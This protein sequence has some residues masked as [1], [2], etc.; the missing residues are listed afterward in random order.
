MP[1]PSATRYRTT[2]WSDYNAALR[3]RGSLSVWFDPE[4][5][6]HAKK[7]GKRGRPETFS[8]AAIQTCLTL[9]VLFGLPLRQTVGQAESL[10][11]M[12]GLDW[13]V[14][15]HSTLCRR[16]ARIAVQVPYRASRQPLNLLV[17]NEASSAIGPR[18]MPNGIKF[19]GDGEWQARKHGPSR[20]RQW[21]KVHI[22][23]D[24]GTGDVRAVE[25]TSSR[26]GDSPL[27]PE[28]LGQIPPEE[29]IGMV[30]ADGAYDTRRCHGAIIDRGADA[31]IPIRRNGRAWKEDCPAAA[32]R[33]E[34]LRATRRLGRTLWKKW[35]G[36]HVRSRV[37]ARMN[38]L[39]L[40]GERIMSRDPDRQ[41]AEIQIRIAI[42]NRFSALGRAEI[43]AVR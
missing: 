25:F 34:I 17:D 43:E 22:A 5:V 30:T 27:L 6:W 31:V 18:T 36:Y 41:T 9:K 37:E 8:D 32:A 24:A 1:K 19:R 29:T 38:C 16:Q 3:K 23:M 4:M 15:D 12:A 28:L 14:P 11:R 35:T 7:S 40:F 26:Q 10:I 20:R 39:K 13:P 2:N 21:R 42:M 33:N